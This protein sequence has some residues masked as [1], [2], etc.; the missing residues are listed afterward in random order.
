MSDGRGAL[1]DLTVLDLC[2]ERGHFVGKILG[3]MGAR[4]IKIEP[5]RGDAARSVGPFRND[6]R[7]PNQ[8][9]YFWAFN[10]SKEG[11]TLNLEV[12]EGREL[13]G[14]LVAK[15]D[16]VLESFD[17]GYLDSLGIGYSA[18]SEQ[19]PALIMMSI[20]GFGQDGPYRDY[21]T[22]D[23]VALAMSGVMHSC[24]YDDIPGSPP[25]APSGGH[26]YMISGHYAAIGAL[27]ALNWRDMT[28][29]GQHVDA[30]IHEACSGTTEWGIPIY[31]Y[32]GHVVQRQTARHH[33]QSQTPRTMYRTSDGGFVNTFAVFNSPDQWWSFVEWMDSEGMAD[34]IADD[35]RFRDMSLL[36]GGGG[37][38]GKQAFAAIGRFIGAHTAEE[39]Y[40]G[41]QALKY[42]WG[43]VR[44]PDDNL[45]DPHFFEDRGFFVRVEHPEL[46]ESFIYTGGPY[47]SNRTPWNTFR[48][49]LLGQ[50][51]E[52]VY[53]EELGLS[54]QEIDRLRA[55]G[56][57]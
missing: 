31:V 50:Q 27:M 32:Y 47:V 57:I 40:R 41:A 24:G 52:K 33:G 54:R 9:L 42:P 36:R 21:K 13:F 25:I 15:A 4:V 29:E 16:M 34:G 38:E 43:P 22:S 49:P 51:N 5:P 6:V 1:S 39:I 26:G 28:G 2:D 12:P 45:E 37:E 10:T 8:S 3:G 14:T 7:D 23:L 30:S 46:G 35:E 11:I 48:S 20:T 19:H 55:D 56:A 44:S 18:L 53:G 17:P